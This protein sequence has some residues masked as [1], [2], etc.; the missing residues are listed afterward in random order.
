MKYNIKKEKLQHNTE[1]LQSLII[2]LPTNNIRL[3]KSNQ[4]KGG[5]TWLS[6]ILLKEEGCSLGSR[7]DAIWMAI[8]ALTKF[9]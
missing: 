3:N 5:S 2:D 8:I 1:R 7:E 4:E 6:T 9:V